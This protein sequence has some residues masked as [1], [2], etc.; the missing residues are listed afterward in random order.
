MFITRFRH[1]SLIAMGVALGAALSGCAT[2]NSKFGDRNA[3]P[4]G[5]QEDDF[6]WI[7]GADYVPSYAYNDVATWEY[8]DPEVI[9]RE[10]GYAESIGLN[11][12]RVF[13]QIIVYEKAPERFLAN[14]EKFLELCDKHNITMM[15]VLFDS[16]FGGEP[17]FERTGWVANPGNTRVAQEAWPG[18]EK[19]VDDVVGRHIGDKRVV[20]WDIMN[21]PMVA[22]MFAQKDENQQKIW[23]FVRHFTK[24]VG[25]LDPTHA[26]TVGVCSF[27]SM[28]A[29]E[30][31]PRVYSFHSYH[32]DE[33]RH[34]RE[35]QDAKA[36]AADRGKYA[37][38]SET[39]HYGGGQTYAMALRVCREEGVGWYLWE[40]MIGRSPFGTVQGIFYPDGSIRSTDDYCAAASVD[41]RDFSQTVLLKRTFP[42]EEFYSRLKEAL[43]TPTRDWNVERRVA[44]LASRTADHLVAQAQFEREYPGVSEQE[45]LEKALKGDMKLGN[46][47]NQLRGQAAQELHKGLTVARDAYREGSYQTAYATVDDLLAYVA[48]KTQKNE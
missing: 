41:V 10:L 44:L 18:C 29:M 36:F 19:F 28:T 42:R 27:R 46:R 8:F 23:R 37:L 24:Y 13:L 7:R 9:D 3:E 14:F 20:M 11:S 30:A 31:E 35:I 5:W 47:L 21:E 17:D 16:C 32:G 43:S 33:A 45:V 12:V 38:V 25:E 48:K 15:P 26:T 1:T 34:R 2:G 40:L 4:M 6:S 39:G 22:G